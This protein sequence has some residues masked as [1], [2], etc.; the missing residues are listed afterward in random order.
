M[1]N[2][3][4]RIMKEISIEEKA[5][6]YDNIIEKANK[7][8]SENC[9]ACQACIEEL[10]PEFKEN[11]DEKVRKELI[12]LIK[13]FHKKSSAFNVVSQ[14]SMLAWLEKQGKQIPADKVESKDYSSIDPHFGKPIDKQKPKFH[15]GDWI[16]SNDKK[17]TYQ[18]IEVKRGIYVIRDNADNHE[19]HIGIEECEKSGRLWTIQDAKDGDVLVDEDNNIGIYKEIEGIC[20]HS[21][22]YLGC[23]NHLYGFSIGGSHVQNNTKPATKEQREQ[24]KKAISDAGYTF[25]FEK[26]EL[27]KIEKKFNVG[28]EIKTANEEPLAITKIDEKGYW[29]EDLFIC[30]FDDAAKWELAKHFFELGLKAQKGE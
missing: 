18:V 13:D 5:R 6:R 22:F 23:N 11:E 4:K 12:N 9:E 20:W 14:E 3:I 21:Y 29:S 25:D 10:I 27:K 24:L 1:V 26:K 16:I 7:M 2:Q 28:D 8:H 19:Y 15:E 30:D 17:S